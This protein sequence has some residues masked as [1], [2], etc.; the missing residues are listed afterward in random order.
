VNEWV[1]EWRDELVNEQGIN[2]HTMSIMPIYRIKVK[3]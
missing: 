1:N 3:Q 2:E